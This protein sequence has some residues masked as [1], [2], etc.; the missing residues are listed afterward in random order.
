[1]ARQPWNRA[2]LSTELKGPLHCVH[3]AGSLAGLNHHHGL[4]ERGNQPVAQWEVETA[5]RVV[6]GKL[7][8]DGTLTSGNAQQQLATIAGVR[9]MQTRTQDGDHA[10]AYAFCAMH[11][12]LINAAGST[13]D[14][15]DSMASQSGA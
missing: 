2:N 9:L 7:A 10:S 13:R 6:I 3:G 1:M 12:G 4:A 8:E 5:R 11:G 15:R 14:N